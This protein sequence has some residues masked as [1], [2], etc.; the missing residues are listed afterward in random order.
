MNS[1]ASST[2]R[3][4]WFGAPHFGPDGDR[5]YFGSQVHYGSKHAITQ[6]KNQG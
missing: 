5:F 4:Y 3:P 1:K 6:K 2:S